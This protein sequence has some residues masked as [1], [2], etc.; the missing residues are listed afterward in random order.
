MPNAH[1]ASRVFRLFFYVVLSWKVA[2]ERLVFALLCL[3]GGR[4]LRGVVVVARAGAVPLPNVGFEGFPR[5]WVCGEEQW[6]EI[7]GVV[8]VVLFGFSR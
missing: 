1:P 3:F 5:V 8:S 7:L 6:Q 4:R 2:E